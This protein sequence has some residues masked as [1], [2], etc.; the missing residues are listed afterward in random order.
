MQHPQPAPNVLGKHP[1]REG[2]LTER[3]VLHGLGVP[4]PRRHPLLGSLLVFGALP[5]VLL[6]FLLLLL[7]RLLRQKRAQVKPM[8][9]CES[10]PME[11]CG[12]RT[13]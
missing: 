12:S 9:L 11:P 8:L 1:H 10:Q 4:F 2:L 3:A 13:P 5:L 7:G 6:V